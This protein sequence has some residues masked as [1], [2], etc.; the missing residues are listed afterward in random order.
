MFVSYCFQEHENLFNTTNYWVFL[1]NILRLQR[2]NMEN[3]VATIVSSLFSFFNWVYE[4]YRLCIKNVF[5][6]ADSL[7]WNS[8]SLIYD[9]ECSGKQEIL[10]CQQS[11]LGILLTKVHPFLSIKKSQQLNK[12]IN[13]LRTKFGWPCKHYCVTTFLSP[14]FKAM[15]FRVILHKDA[16]WRFGESSHFVSL[17]HTQSLLSYDCRKAIIIDFNV[18]LPFNWWIVNV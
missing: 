9:G 4:N 1:C 12:P 14:A 11:M 17:A 7:I 2:N 5:F 10:K 3:N 18:Y 13:Y 8:S 15:N 6:S 16:T